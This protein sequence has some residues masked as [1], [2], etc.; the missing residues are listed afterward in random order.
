MQIYGNCEDF[1]FFCALFGLVMYE[2][3]CFQWRAVKLQWCLKLLGLSYFFSRRF[4]DV[5]GA[6]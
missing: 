1:P 6:R 4:D 5:G 2:N 3:P